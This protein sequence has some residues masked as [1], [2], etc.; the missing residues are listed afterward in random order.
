[1]SITKG[2]ELRSLV[3]SAGELQLSLDTVELPPPG[4]GEVLVRVEASPINPSDLILLL[5]TADLNTLQAVGTPDKPRLSAVVPPKTL[6]ALGARLDKS[7]T[8]GNEGAGVVIGAGSGA[9]ALM[10]KTVA[11]ASGGMYAQYRL[12]KSAECIVLNDDASPAD[13]ASAFVN[14]LTALGMT[15]TMRNEG[16]TALIHT[17]AA[18]NLG[19]ML[20][21]I[22]IAD[23]IPLVNIVRSAEQE[24]LLRGIGARYVVDST[25]ADF[26]K[27]LADAAAETGATLA[28]DAIGGGT[29]ASQILTAMEIA[30]NRK[31]GE[32][33]RYGSTVMKQVYIYGAL[34]PSPTILNRSFGLTWGAGG[35][36]LSVFL[37][38]IGREEGNRLRS[39]VVNELKTTFA[40]HYSAEISLAEALQPSILQA[41]ARRATGQKYLINPGRAA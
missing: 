11:L 38:K 36:L 39:R 10:G 17:A 12:V 41:Y 4:P 6:K 24:K 40:S 34:D 25:A 13:G 29:L 22:C 30:A 3:T 18:S 32:Y 37:A 26:P 20:N 21:R 28:F 2:L 19:Q 16:H 35:W 1:M 15:V 14:P 9:E 5:G 8:V 27:N 23:G 33:S 31:N 7:M